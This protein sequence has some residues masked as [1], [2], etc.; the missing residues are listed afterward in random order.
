LIVELRRSLALPLDD[1]VEAMRRCLAPKLSRSGIH[2]CLKRHGLSARPDPAT[3]AGRHLPN[4]D[5]GRLHPHRCRY[6][7]RLG[8]RPSYAYVAI[9][10]ATRLVYLDII[11]DRWAATAAFLARFLDRLLLPVHTILTDKGYEFTDRFAVDKEAKPHGRSSG[12]HPF[13]QSAPRA[14]LPTASRNRSGRRPTV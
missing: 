1:I 12:D 3:G 10:R 5:P 14:P 11:P 4:R 6:L 2:R 8:R 9:D 13:D 7:P